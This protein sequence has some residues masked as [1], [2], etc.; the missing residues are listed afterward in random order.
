MAREAAARAESRYGAA[1]ACIEHFPAISDVSFFGE[2]DEGWLAVVRANTPAW[3]ESVPWPERGGIAGVPTIN[4]GPWG[5]DY[6]TPLER[7]HVG[8]AF[9]TLPRLLLDIATGVLEPDE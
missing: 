4:V 3:D 6:H 9:G 2:A 5:R 1:V 7:L 8:Y